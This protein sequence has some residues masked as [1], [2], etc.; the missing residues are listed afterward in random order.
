MTT[1]GIITQARMTS[2][3]LP[4]KVLLPAGS[5]T[6]LDHH[7]DRLCRVDLP[8]CI[9]TTTNSTDDPLATLG[10]RRGISVF[11]GSEDD[12][13][14]RFVGAADSLGL[15]VI[16]RVT[17]DCPLIDG[18]IVS[19]GVRAF[20]QGDNPWL[21]V[22]NAL[23]RTFPRGMDFEVFSMMALRHA[24]HNATEAY[25]RE[26]VTPYFYQ[27][28][29]PRTRLENIANATNQSKYRLTL[30]TPEDYKLLRCLI[31]NYNAAELPVA[32]LVAILTSHPKLS[33]ING[34]IEQK[35]LG[36]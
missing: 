22:S 32:S 11:R 21:Y 7:L 3:R 19:E 25:Q 6:M 24:D 4:G 31:E 29:D 14:S 30:D 28:I 20:L 5:S 27:R 26:H 10:E 15:D 36:E 2:T 34:H 9:A 13:L 23:R 17:S 16:V 8:I 12:V 35:K 1:V 18:A 33:A